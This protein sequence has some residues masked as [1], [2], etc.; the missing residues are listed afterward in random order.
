MS[1]ENKEEKKE[2]EKEE[3]LLLPEGLEEQKE[4]EKKN[5]TEE[6]IK[7]TIKG[8]EKELPK[9]INYVT[10]I[11]VDEER[12]LIVIKDSKL[13]IGKSLEN[14]VDIQKYIEEGSATNI[15]NA[16]YVLRG[17]VPSYKE[18]WSGKL[19]K[20]AKRKQNQVF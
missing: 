14:C 1:E 19:T 15:I 20:E 17:M 18:M 8:I 4:P 10:G 2:D 13:M 5:E 16:L 12:N 3:E 9:N 7:N 11:M 6:F